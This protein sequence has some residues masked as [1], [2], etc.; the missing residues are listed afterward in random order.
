MAKINW[1]PWMGLARVRAMQDHWGREDELAA[2]DRPRGA[3]GY[4]WQPMADVYEA[5]DGWRLLVELPGVA[6]EDM[7][8][9]IDGRMLSV[10]GVRRFERGPEGGVFQALERSYGPFRRDFALP[11][12]LDSGQIS[13]VLRDGLL[14]VVISRSGGPRRRRILVDD[15]E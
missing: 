12:G 3:D 15:V 1:T 14:T 10:F 7:S 2:A 11:E 6:R 4:T 9:E 13:A 5:P 8:L